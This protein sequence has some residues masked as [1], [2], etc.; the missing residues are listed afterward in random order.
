MIDWTTIATWVVLAPTALLALL[1]NVY[2]AKQTE[3]AVDAATAETVAAIAETKA[4]QD[5]TGALI[6]QAEASAEGSKGL[7]D[8]GRRSATHTRVR[9]ATATQLGPHN[10]SLE[11]G[12]WPRVQGGSRLSEYE[13]TRDTGIATN[14]CWPVE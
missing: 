9:V 12:P 5:Q 3:R 2:Q 10:T 11:Y 8:L 14:S 7:T 13:R 4:A 1:A 6:R